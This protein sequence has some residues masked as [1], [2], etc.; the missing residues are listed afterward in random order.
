MDF[1]R[2]LVSYNLL[3]KHDG[4]DV[5]FETKS[6]KVFPWLPVTS[7]DELPELG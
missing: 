1:L 2:G 5:P 3:G 4:S 7:S 6:S